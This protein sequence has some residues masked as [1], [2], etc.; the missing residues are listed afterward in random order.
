MVT[1]GGGEGVGVREKRGDHE[2][3]REKVVFLLPGCLRS[4]GNKEGRREGQEQKQAVVSAVGMTHRS[5][6]K[7]S[8][9][10]LYGN[11]RS[12]GKP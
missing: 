11:G 4:R 3:P 9:N 8:K 1:M 10:R 2:R 6:S 5:M 7:L 12:G